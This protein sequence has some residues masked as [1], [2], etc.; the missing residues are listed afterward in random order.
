MLGPTV[1]RPVSL[2]IKH[3]SG[4]YDQIF[5]SLCQLRSCFC[6][7]P[8]LTRG[9]VCLLYTMRLALASAVFLVS[10]SLGDRDHILLSQI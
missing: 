6:G 7:A 3:Q 8:S 5:I 1:G 2:G 10:E 9:L 4:V